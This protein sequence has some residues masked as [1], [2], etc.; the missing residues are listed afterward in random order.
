MQFAKINKQ[1]FKKKKNGRKLSTHITC[2]LK[3]MK[4]RRSVHE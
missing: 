1:M 2:A 3:E 4:H